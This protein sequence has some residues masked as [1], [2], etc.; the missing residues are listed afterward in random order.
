MNVEGMFKHWT[1]NHYHAEYK[2][3]TLWACNGFF[4]FKDGER[5]RKPLLSGL[6]TGE[7]GCVWKEYQK[8]MRSRCLNNIK[9]LL[10]EKEA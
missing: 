5:A 3:Y 1:F 7:R 2:D 8:E 6:A 4:H 9:E 10:D